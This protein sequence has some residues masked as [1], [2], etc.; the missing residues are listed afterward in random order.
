MTKEFVRLEKDGKTITVDKKLQAEY[1]T[2]GWR[3]IDGK[4]VEQKTFTKYPTY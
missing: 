1:V 3:V 2:A 4:T